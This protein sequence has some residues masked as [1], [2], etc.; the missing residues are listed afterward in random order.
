MRLPRSH[1]AQASHLSPCWRGG[2]GG[3][4]CV[5]VCAHPGLSDDLASLKR[6]QR[7]HEVTEHRHT[8]RL[9][10]VQHA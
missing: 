5:C 9:A 4:V 10:A 6:R 1:P 2:G 3:G 8:S 7:S